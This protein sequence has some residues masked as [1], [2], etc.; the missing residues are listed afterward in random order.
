MT[1]FNDVAQFDQS[2]V[3]GAIVSFVPAIVQVAGKNTSDR[4]IAVAA[5]AGTAASMY[6]LAQGGKVGKQAA[7]NLVMD[8]LA[9]I[10]AQ[11]RSG[12]Y[13]PLAEALAGITGESV[14]ITSRATFESLPDQYR[15]KQCDVEAGKNGGWNAAGDKMSSKLS[16]VIQCLT[17]VTAVQEGIAAMVAQ[18]Q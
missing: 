1:T 4:R 18:G 7:K 15:A 13:K 10:T 5:S 3:T 9:S 11:S 8:G 2:A 12:N 6:L 17:L 16:A 14:F